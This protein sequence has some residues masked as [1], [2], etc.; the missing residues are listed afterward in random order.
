V[1]NSSKQTEKKQAPPTDRGVEICNGEEKQE[2]TFSAWT[3]EAG[4]RAPGL[5]TVHKST[6]A[7]GQ[8]WVGAGL[9]K[10]QRN[11]DPGQGAGKGGVRGKIRGFSAASRR[12][13]MYQLAKIDR[14]ELPLWCT[15]TFPDEFHEFIDQPKVWKVILKRLKM[16]FKRKYP[17]AGGFWRLELKDRLSGL[18]VG[19]WFP[20]FHLLIYGIDELEF[21]RWL[22][23]NWWE[24][25]GKLSSDHLGRGTSCER[26]DSYRKLCSYVSKYMAKV[27]GGDMELGRVWGVWSVENI[28]FVKAILVV[29]DEKEAVQ[30]LRLMRRFARIRSRDYRSLK[31]M[32]DAEFWWR[33][34]DKLLYPR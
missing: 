22:A 5:L 18:Y 26:V 25:C 14:K 17:G 24:V 21:R 29:L 4:K 19:E 15:L 7:N 11:S 3:M 8:F 12:R 23:V 31:I 34:L 6:L 16:R 28:P 20:H 13:M 30:L 9:V 32:C 27:E 1:L 2:C 10:V 33:N